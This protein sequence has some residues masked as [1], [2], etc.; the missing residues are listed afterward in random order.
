MSGARKR[1]LSSEVE[2]LQ[3]GAEEHQPPRHVDEPF[4]AGNVQRGVALPVARLQDR[5]RAAVSKESV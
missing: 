3:V 4:E 1:G 5:A 2:R